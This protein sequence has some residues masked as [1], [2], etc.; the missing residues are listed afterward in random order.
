MIQEQN[1]AQQIKIMADL[2]AEETEEDGIE[3]GE[4]LSDS[5]LYITQARLQRTC[6]DEM[7][8][9]SN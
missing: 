2:L 8:R 7:I 9:I 4:K 1:V 6:S 3:N 5:A